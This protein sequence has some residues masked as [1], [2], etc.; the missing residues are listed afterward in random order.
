MAMLCFMHMW[1]KTGTSLLSSHSRIEGAEGGKDARAKAQTHTPEMRL[2]LPSQPV[3]ACVK[4]TGLIL[5][6]L[7]PSSGAY[8]LASASAIVCVL[9]RE[10][11]FGLA[12]REAFSLSLSTPGNNSKTRRGGAFFFLLLSRARPKQRRRATSARR[13]GTH[14]QGNTMEGHACVMSS[15]AGAA[16]KQSRERQQAF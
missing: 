2:P 13:E 15:T 12:P 14:T 1:I 9:E 11:S 5:L 10:S 6:L 4:V 7:P 3:C 16:L 8:G